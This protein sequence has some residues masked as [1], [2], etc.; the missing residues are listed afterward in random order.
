V[1]INSADSKAQLAAL[2]EKLIAGQCPPEIQLDVYEA[3]KKAGLEDL[4]AKWK[5]SLPANDDLANYKLSL[6][7]G[8]AERGRK[9]F[10]EKPETSCLRCHKCEIGDSLVGPELTHIAATKDRLYLLES[11]V[12]PNRK[13]AEGFQTVSVELKDKNFV[14]G[15]L[16]GEDAQ[17]IRLETMDET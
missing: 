11:I 5:S 10:R 7:G 9:L 1:Q 4:A 14:V 17:N 8:D 16:V 3:A 15:R 12:Y 2:M 13:I 6:A